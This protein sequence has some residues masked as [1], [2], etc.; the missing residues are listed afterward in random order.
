MPTPQPVPTP[1]LPPAPKVTGP[2][3]RYLAHPGAETARLLHH[4]GV[5]AWH[6]G[7]SVGPV[8]AALGIAAAVTVAAARRAQARRLHDGA[9]L[10]KVLAPPDVDPHG[11]A[12]LWTNLVALLRP[13]WRRAL[14]GQ[15]HLGFE[16]AATDAG[17]TRDP[18]M[19]RVSGGGISAKR[20]L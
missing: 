18:P 8:V 2:L 13:A 7:V 9:R 11:A 10:F 20:A 14:G 12:T 1:P 3:A 19:W 5:L 17:L 15:P 6:L 16:L 4:L